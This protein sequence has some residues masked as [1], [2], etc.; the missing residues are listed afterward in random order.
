M[1]DSYDLFSA[2]NGADE[3]LVARSDF[4]VRRKHHMLTSLL[5]VAA[6]AAIILI[7]IFSLLLSPDPS[8][9]NVPPTEPSSEVTTPGVNAGSP[10]QLSG[11]NIGSLNIIQLADSE[12]TVSMPDFLMNVNAQKYR[13]GEGGGIY[14]ISPISSTENM[15]DC[16][17]TIT[18]QPD[19]SLE[20]AAQQ[21]LSVLSSTMTSV[22]NS[23]TDLLAGG[24]LIRG[25]NGSEWDATQ[26]EI[27]ITGDLQGGVFIFTL[28]YYQADTDG[29]A[30]WFRDML[31]TFEVITAERDAPAWMRDLRNS[32]GSFT[33]A[34]LKND[35]SDVQD[36]ISENADIY[37]YDADV[38]FGTRVLK[39]HYTV[40][41]SDGP[42]T[43][44][45]SVRHKYLEN[46]AYDYIT[47]EL[48]YGGGKWQIVWAMIER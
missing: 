5:P 3:N 23:P 41:S 18:W 12:E 17:M 13:I 37:T 43:A 10:L 38:F 7:S 9:L 48:K 2:M 14:Y 34:F 6:C 4:H 40:D 24:L 31:Q 36:L 16:L 19:I 29:H 21:Q 11:S 1:M 44:Q 33:T 15:P 32:V 26:T 45:V 47:M 35:F 30:I 42:T 28:Q 20:E 39:T 8:T 46:D 22:T 27:Y 25:S